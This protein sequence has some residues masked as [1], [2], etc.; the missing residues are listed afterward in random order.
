M[1]LSPVIT[2]AFVLHLEHH[3]FDRWTAEQDAA[4]AAAWEPVRQ[5]L[6]ALRGQPTLTELAERQRLPPPTRLKP[7]PGWPPI[8]IPGQPGRYLT[9]DQ[10]RQDAA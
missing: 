1:E 10:D 8:A 5:R 7:T 2:D 4:E 6:A 3:L 9:L